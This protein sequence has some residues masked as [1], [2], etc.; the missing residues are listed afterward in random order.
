VPVNCG[1]RGLPYGSHLLYRNNGDGTFTDVTA[2]SGIG[3]T[4]G[5]FGLTV[6][7]ADFDND[8]WPDIYVACDSTPSLLFRNNHDGTFTEQGLERG[9]ALSEDGME[10]AG[11]GVAVA[12]FTLSG[13][14]DI[15]KT[16]FA[17]DTPA[18]YINNGKGR[19][20]DSTRRAG[21]AVETRFVTW[22]VCAADLDNDG[23]PDLFFVTGS[24]YPE[25]DGK[26]PGM[27]FR[28]PRVVF[29]NLGKGQFEELMGEAGPAVDE[30]H[31]SR[32]CACGDFDNDGDL[33]LVVINQNEPP[34]LL[35]ND[36]TGGNHWL[37]I[38]LAGVRSNRS[39]IGARVTVRYGDRVQA[40]E[41]LSQSS[42]LSVSDRRLHF[43]LGGAGAA[44][45]EIRWPQ[46]QIERLEHV[47]ADRLIHVTEGAGITRSERF[48]AGKEPQ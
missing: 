30:P 20:R 31:S 12:D 5:G 7:A 29:R 37:K 36:V 44:D 32:G 22:G 26:V 42:Y 25:A 3:K 34:S 11:M 39:A 15:L 24:I 13:S 41:V 19:F 17:N 33:D 38:R 45:V 16:H 14:L 47:A 48:G 27:P 1:P 28:T 8:G 10:Q 9:V 21:L 18:L 40:Q 43:G 6:A 4:E 2:A 35:R 46:G 23:W